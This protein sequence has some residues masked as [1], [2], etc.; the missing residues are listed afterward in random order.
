MSQRDN[1]H[2]EEYWTDLSSVID[3]QKERMWDAMLSGFEKYSHVLKERSTLIGETDS[4]RQQV[5]DKLIP[6]VLPNVPLTF[7][8]RFSDVMDVVKALKQ[9]CVRT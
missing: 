9:R 2:D 1:T 7:I 8:R 3:Q 5:R 4:L 6:I